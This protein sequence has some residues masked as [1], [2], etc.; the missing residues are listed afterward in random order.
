MKRISR[1]IGLALLAVGGRSL[2][3]GQPPTVIV[4]AVT[5]SASYAPSGPD[6]NWIAQ[7]S[8]FVV[9]GSNL[10]PARIE[11]SSSFRLP[12][13]LA[14]SSV[15]VQVG[16]STVDAIMIYASANQ[17]AAVLPSKTPIGDGT[18]TVSFTNHMP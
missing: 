10:G 8:L 15:Q 5:N 13:S 1:C 14:G 11:H 2:L 7:G 17:L 4:A 16:G 6:K 18:L 12:F 9:F 3:C